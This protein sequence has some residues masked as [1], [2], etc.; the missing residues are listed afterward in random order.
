MPLPED[1]WNM[2][3]KEPHLQMRGRV[4]GTQFFILRVFHRILVL[5]A[6]SN[7]FGMKE[8][9]IFRVKI[10]SWNFAFLFENAYALNGKS[11]WTQETTKELKKSTNERD[12]PHL[13]Y[14]TVDLGMKMTC[15]VWG[16]DQKFFVALVCKWELM[17]LSIYNL[18]CNSGS[19]LQIRIQNP[20]VE[21]GFR[22]QDFW[23]ERAQSKK[24][25]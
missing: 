8:K 3:K 23:S 4:F 14:W 6:G 10:G 7:N 19:G 5:N 20:T 22:V 15:K 2:G 13:G 11:F 16:H 17:L 21:P 9:L 18:G 12:R 25:N 24:K 1:G